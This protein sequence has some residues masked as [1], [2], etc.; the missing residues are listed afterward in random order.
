MSN[1]QGQTEFMLMMFLSIKR[2]Q[3]VVSNNNWEG[4]KQRQQENPNEAKC[5]HSFCFHNITFIFN[6]I[7][8]LYWNILS[9]FDKLI[10]R[11]ICYGLL[12]LIIISSIPKELL[13]K[14]Y[15][16]HKYNILQNMPRIG[17]FNAFKAAKIIR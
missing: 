10:T 15:I 3:L 13:H 12:N 11:I 17:L 2:W 4:H 14:Y 5:F 6:I 7:N 16:L 8:V 9:K 1:M